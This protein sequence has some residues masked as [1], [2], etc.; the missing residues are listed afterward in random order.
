MYSST[1]IS[2]QTIII[3]VP[4]LS[5]GKRKNPRKTT[6]KS[7]EKPRKILEKPYFVCIFP[8]LFDI[9]SIIIALYCPI[10]VVSEI[11]CFLG[12]IF[13]TQG[14][15]GYEGEGSGQGGGEERQAL[16]TKRKTM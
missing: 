15:L 11:W 5:P 1:E 2:G 9:F 12:Q 8:D 10:T 7:Q 4:P 6:R 16:K 3:I 14:R 13:L